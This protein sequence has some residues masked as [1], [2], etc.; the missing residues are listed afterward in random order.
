MQPSGEM[1]PVL[2]TRDPTRRIALHRL[3]VDLFEAGELRRWIRY[4]P[5]AEIMDALPTEQA[6]MD[7]LVEKLM[8]ELENRGFL[9]AEFFEHVRHERP[10]RAKE[11]QRVAAA[12]LSVHGRA[13]RAGDSEGDAGPPRLLRPAVLAL[14][15]AISIVLGAVVM[16]FVPAATVVASILAVFLFLVAVVFLCARRVKEGALAG[17]MGAFALDRATLITSITGV[18]VGAPVGGAVG[19]ELRQGGSGAGAGAGTAMEVRPVSPAGLQLILLPTDGET[20]AHAAQDANGAQD[21]RTG[22]PG[23]GPAARGAGR[24]GAP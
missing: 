16:R 3:F 14:S 21:H 11:I 19:Y 9:G 12:W 13:A 15:L 10:K 2:A 17:G 20:K 1:A 7:D 24:H 18:A 8:V 5:Y 4:G 6:A 23:F 22:E